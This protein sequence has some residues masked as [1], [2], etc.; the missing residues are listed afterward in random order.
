MG[1][2]AVLLLLNLVKSAEVGKNRIYVSIAALIDTVARFITSLERATV[3]AI[4]KLDY[5]Y[6]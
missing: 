6:N 4:C 2:I 5:V 3:V 1:R